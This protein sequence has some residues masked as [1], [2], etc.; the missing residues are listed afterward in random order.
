M[1]H[2]SFELTEPARLFHCRC[3]GYGGFLA[4]FLEGLLALCLELPLVGMK[5]TSKAS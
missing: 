1:L 3:H 4:C 5:P 2:L